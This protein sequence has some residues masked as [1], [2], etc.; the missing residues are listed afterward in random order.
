VLRRLYVLP[1][2]ALVCDSVRLSAHGRRIFCRFH[3][4]RAHLLPPSTC[5][6]AARL[7]G[8]RAGSSRN[9]G[10]EEKETQQEDSMKYLLMIVAAIALI[11][12]VSATSRSAD[13][14][15]GGIC[16]PLQSSCCAE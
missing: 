14:C 11:G 1:G 9:C 5:S 8:C 12:T 10:N 7:I 4:F 15:G 6:T 3:Y 16:C 13:C 2:G